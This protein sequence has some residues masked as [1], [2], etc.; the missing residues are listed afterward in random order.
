[1]PVITFLPDEHVK[2][3]CRIVKKRGTYSE[4]LWPD[5]VKT[6]MWMEGKNLMSQM[7][8]EEF[9]KQILPNSQM[10]D[11]MAGDR[12]IGESGF[13]KSVQYIQQRD[14][15]PLGLA[16]RVMLEIYM[17]HDIP[18]HVAIPPELL[19][20]IE[21]GTLEPRAKTNTPSQRTEQPVDL[22]SNTSQKEQ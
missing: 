21:I 22:E 2:R 19:D 12:F 10:D 7:E 17:R 4:I 11:V 6:R 8:G 20:T 3:L 14:N 1:M 15:I 13:S 9:I 5:R 16:S 18:K